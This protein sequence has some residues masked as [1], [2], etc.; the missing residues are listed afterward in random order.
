[1]NKGRSN[2]LISK[3]KSRR[4]T[5]TKK[6]NKTEVGKQSIHEQEPLSTRLTDNEIKFRS[7]YSDS[8]DV[9]F[10]SFYIGKKDKAILIYIEGLSS[11]EEI[12]NSVLSPLMK[13]AEEKD[14]QVDTLIN[15]SVSVSS[16][17]EVK[18]F[19]ECIGEISSVI[20]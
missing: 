20:Q 6:K 5:N 19:S 12:D 15:K 13:R 7:I 10:R 2:R 18:T 9:I 8:S 1:M 11:V 17:K 3:I 14:Y 4:S 16:V